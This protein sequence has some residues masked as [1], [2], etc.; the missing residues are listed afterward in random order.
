MSTI[1]LAFCQDLQ[2]LVHLYN[3][4][5]I[6]NFAVHDAIKLNCIKLYYTECSA[7]NNHTNLIHKLSFCI[8]IYSRSTI[9]TLHHRTGF[10][11]HVLVLQ[12]WV[13]M[14]PF[15]QRCS[16]DSSFGRGF[17]VLLTPAQQYYRVSGQVHSNVFKCRT[18]VVFWVPGDLG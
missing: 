11:L 1:V 8:V 13:E 10:Q 9:R 5:V 7:Q 16:Q 3:Q 6:Q 14:T 4:P 18:F 17:F 12:V 15:L 2:P